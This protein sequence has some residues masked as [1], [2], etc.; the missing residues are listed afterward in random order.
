[1]DMPFELP[2][3]IRE[4]G[5]PGRNTTLFKYGCSLRY[6]GVPDEEIGLKLE[7]A[8]KQNCMPP[9][10]DGE[11]RTI[12]GQV[13]KQD[14]GETNERTNPDD[15]HRQGNHKE[16]QP[17][18]L[19][20]TE[21]AALQLEKLFLPDEYV[22]I[23][24]RSKMTSLDKWTPADRGKLYNVGN[25][26]VKL[27]NTAKFESV[28]EYYNPKAGIWFCAN[29]ITPKGKRSDKDVVAFRHVLVEYDSGLKDAQ[30]KNLMQSGMP[31]TTIT[32]SGGKS[33]HALI[34]ID[35]E[36]QRH[37][38]MCAEQI[39][40]LLEKKFG[41]KP[42]TQ[43]S[44]PSRLT[45]LAGA[46]RGRN[47][48]T[49]YYTDVNVFRKIESWISSTIDSLALEE[50]ELDGKFK[51]NVMGDHLIRNS[52]ACTVDGMPVI[53]GMNGFEVG[54]EPLMKE[55]LRKRPDATKSQ[56]NE[57]ISYLK[58]MAPSAKQADAR[59][60]R[61]KNGILD[62]K[63]MEFSQ[64]SNGHMVLN[65]IP[66]NYNPDA[67]LKFVDGVVDRIAQGD[68]AVV[69][70]IW[71]MFGLAMYR[72]HE[73]ARLILLHG[74]GANGKST[75]LKLLQEILGGDNFFPMSLQSLGERFQLVQT[76]GKLAL[77]GDDIPSDCI[78]GTTCA[79]LK[80]FVTGEHVTDEY[81]GGETFTF[82]PYSTLI[83]ACNE[84]PV[85]KDSSYGLERRIHP[86]PLTATFTPSDS[87]YDAQLGEKLAHRLCVEH[88]IAKA[89]NALHECLERKTMTPNELSASLA[90]DILRS[91]DCVILFIEEMKQAGFRLDTERDIVY[92]GFKSWC[93]RNGFQSCNVTQFSRRLCSIE[94][95]E[96]YSSNGKRYYRKKSKEAA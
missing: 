76:I 9:M 55:I 47:E 4:G 60:I 64:M 30:M 73:V 26:I 66:H 38:K 5:D 75:L 53:C 71:E 51:H 74:G 62:V 20:P 14:K 36:G 78:N 42:D 27:R 35:A 45:R 88:A 67:S 37:Y 15:S 61:F 1:M 69:A 72:G 23:V 87:N 86:I 24:T 59:Y 34:R 19:P 70:N 6:K 46:S 40:S 94:G 65:E 90:K 81:K 18:D 80:K 48:Q 96:S 77:I 84:I 50:L 28:F 25:L 91:N 43:N 58:L 16:P 79:A 2:N 39:Y 11:L 32:D 44:N 7:E 10:S 54:C 31:I 57:T 95:F 17:L 33:V 68:P 12:I 56:R 63:T 41:S 85:F 29:P 3:I 52:G 22:C 13:L 21:Q 93:L 83:Y 92:E 49:L 82:M 8:N 89:M